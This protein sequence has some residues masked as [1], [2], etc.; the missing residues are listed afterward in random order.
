VQVGEL[1]DAQPLEP[2][3]K[4]C[5]AHAPLDDLRA[6]ERVRHT[7]IPRCE[8]GDRQR[9]HGELGELAAREHEARAA[10]RGRSTVR[11]GASSTSGWA[12]RPAS[13]PGGA[14]P[15]ARLSTAARRGRH[16]GSRPRPSRGSP[17][18]AHAA[19]C[20]LVARRRGTRSR[21]CWRSGAARDARGPRAASVRKSAKSITLLVPTITVS[22]I[23]SEGA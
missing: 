22:G 23:A 15:R 14:R 20:E 12:P 5:E 3:R 4:P 6:T 16:E 10:E 18:S 19:R 13:A 17:C 2:G 9:S 1:E 8:R 21:T 11:G 7:Q